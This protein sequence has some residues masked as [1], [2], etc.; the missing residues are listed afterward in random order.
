MAILACVALVAVVALAVFERTAGSQLSSPAGATQPI[1]TS[2]KVRVVI[3]G[4]NHRYPV[5][6]GSLVGKGT[7]KA[8][9]AITD[10]GPALAYR[11]V[12]ADGRFITLRFVTKGKNGTTTYLVKI[13]TSAGTSRWSIASGTGAYN[14]SGRETENASY[15]VS[16]LTGV[17]SR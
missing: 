14:G 13:D 11:T 7:F 1:F 9:G 6:D 2:G 8:S 3:R 16:I 17:V 10:A 4:T 12:N 5:T 15:M